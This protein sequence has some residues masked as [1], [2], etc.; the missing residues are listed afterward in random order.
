METILGRFDRAVAFAAVAEHGGFTRAAERLKQ[1][2]AHVSKQVA[3]LEQAL[4]V[5]LLLRTT[6]RVS[7][8]E[9][10]RVYLESVRQ[11]RETLL[12]GERAVS[13]TRS[14]VSGTLRLTAPSSFGDT[15]LPQLILEFRAQYPAVDVDLDLSIVR[16][17]L[18]A[19]GFDLAFRAAHAV[20]ESLVARP[21]GVLRDHLVASPAFLASHAP[22]ARPSDL[23]R[24]PCIVNSHFR[25]DAH[26]SFVQG[27]ASE[28]VSVRGP[29]RINH[30]SAIRRACIAGAGVAKLP[31][32][33][34]VDELAAGRLVRVLGGHDLVALPMYL[35]YPQRR[36]QPLRL[37]VFVEFVLRSFERAGMRELFA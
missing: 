9:A 13:L 37:R 1:S 14:D 5:Q 35:L 23:A 36:H 22:I 19:D 33:L 12:D 24:L 6:R 10:G 2:K 11:A 27:E 3:E 17:D 26:W 25:D 28:T 20:D 8:T 32:Y 18:V 7:L 21:L 15:F 34:L 30:Y 29:I 31:R 16:R 4:G